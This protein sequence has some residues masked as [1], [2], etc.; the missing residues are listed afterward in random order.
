MLVRV[1]VV[2][3]LT[4]EEPLRDNQDGW[5][6]LALGYVFS[7]VHIND[8]KVVPHGPFDIVLYDISLCSG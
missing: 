8:T 5:M 3:S 1:L 7:D 2:G 6:Y 4:E